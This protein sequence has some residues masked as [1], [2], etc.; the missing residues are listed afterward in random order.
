MLID[1]TG[2]LRATATGGCSVFQ[3]QLD[4]SHFAIVFGKNPSGMRA[5]IR[6]ESSLYE[7]RPH[8][9]FCEL[10]SSLSASRFAFGYAGQDAGTS[11]RGRYPPLPDTCGVA[12][13]S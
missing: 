7:L 10:P 8:R 11:R 9:S 6:L 13:A 5:G 2:I 3:L 1:E 4:M 12:M